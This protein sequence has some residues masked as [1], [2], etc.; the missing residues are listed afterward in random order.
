MDV[1]SKIKNLKSDVIKSS[2]YSANATTKVRKLVDEIISGLRVLQGRTVSG[3][4]P[5]N[6][7]LG[8]MMGPSGSNGM[9]VKNRISIIADINDIKREV[10]NTREINQQLTQFVNSR[11]EMIKG[12]R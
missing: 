9:F 7:V 1:L 6:N 10:T 8:N 11:L 3:S 4:N 12:M 2:D 5:F